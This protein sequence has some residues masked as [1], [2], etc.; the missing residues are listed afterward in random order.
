MAQNL[1]YDN[2]IATTVDESNNVNGGHSSE[3]SLMFDSDMSSNCGSINANAHDDRNSDTTIET[4]GAEEMD[5]DINEDEDNLSDLSNSLGSTNGD[6]TSEMDTETENEEHTISFSNVTTEDEDVDHNNTQLSNH[7]D[8]ED[9][10][11]IGE[12][13]ASEVHFQ[14]VSTSDSYANYSESHVDTTAI[15]ELLMGNAGEKSIECLA[16][17]LLDQLKKAQEEGHAG[18]LI[19]EWNQDLNISSA[20]RSTEELI[21]E[22]RCDDKLN[23]ICVGS[24]ASAAQTTHPREFFKFSFVREVMTLPFH[25]G[26]L[27]HMYNRGQIDGQFILEPTFN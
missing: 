6:L 20:L 16:V 14:S 23:N 13:N 9:G 25:I 26:S 2:T 5:I 22:L 17:E 21:E 3:S 1:H 8:N 24:I 18:H 4:D 11:S 10:R 15:S 7:V 27:Y 12:S 19:Y